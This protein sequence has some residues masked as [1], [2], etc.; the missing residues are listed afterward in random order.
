MMTADYGRKAY[1]D[2]M[3]AKDPTIGRLVE[4]GYEFVTN[5]FTPDAK[6]QSVQMKDTQ[7]FALLL[8]QEGYLVELGQ[9]YSEKGDL[10]TTMQS[11]WRKRRKEA[12]R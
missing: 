9:A 7:A 1:I 3:V 8:K 10:I 11:V 12:D 5:A 4:R 6:P 2:L